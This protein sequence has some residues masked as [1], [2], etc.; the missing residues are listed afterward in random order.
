VYRLRPLSAGDLDLVLVWRNDPRVRENMYTNHVISPEE[1][2]RWFDKASRDES[3]RLLMCED[4]TAV[5]VGVVTFSDID[6]VHRRATWAFYSGDTTRRG[7][8]SK[9][10]RLALDYAFSSLELEKLNCEVLSFNMPVV[11]FHRKHGFRV[12]GIFRNQF[13]RDGVTH[14]VYRLAHFRKDWIEYVRPAIIRAQEGIP[15]RL[16]PGASHRE[17]LVLTRDLI[18]R[19]SVLTGDDNP[20]HLQD[21][22][23]REAGFEGVLAHGMLVAAGISRILGTVFPGPGTIYVG[24]SLQFL[25]PVYPDMRIEYMVR[26]VSRVGRKAIL[27][28]AVYTE[29]GK[30]AVTGEAEVL[31]P[32]SEG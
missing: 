19:Y 3:K 28:T 16:K 17:T 25:R 7:V 5:P 11:E 4:E 32:K 8:G 23:A 1:H 30:I 14:D 24:Q 15:V 12:E 31:L 27:N 22:V 6:P 20:V 10:E 9:M 29:D 18:S 2:R 13:R 26:I 21:S